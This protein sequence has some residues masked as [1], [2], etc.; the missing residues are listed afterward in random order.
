MKVRRQSTLRSIALLI[1]AVQPHVSRLL[2][3]NTKS[4]ATTP[5]KSDGNIHNSFP[6][7]CLHWFSTSCQILSNAFVIV[8]QLSL[9]NLLLPVSILWNYSWPQKNS[10]NS[11]K[12]IFVQ[13][14]Q[15]Y[16][17]SPPWP[18]MT[19]LFKTDTKAELLFLLPFHKIKKNK[20]IFLEFNTDSKQNTRFC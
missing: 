15:F 13:S 20:W 12:Y 8:K 18:A 7:V 16:R 14:K 9:F 11:R 10:E 3:S 2:H 1:S 6:L 19:S 5:G 17:L 4:Q